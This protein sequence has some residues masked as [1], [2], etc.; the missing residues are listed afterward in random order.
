MPIIIYSAYESNNLYFLQKSWVQNRFR[1]QSATFQSSS[2]KNDVL[3]PWEQV[4]TSRHFLTFILYRL[5]RAN[6]PWNWHLGISRVYF[7]Y[8]ENRL[9]NQVSKLKCLFSI[10]QKQLI[11]FLYFESI[12]LVC[13]LDITHNNSLVHTVCVW[14]L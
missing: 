2:F 10:C 1:L 6:T 5:M 14:F 8:R 12:H 9:P 7:I 11:C 13:I 3:R 4:K